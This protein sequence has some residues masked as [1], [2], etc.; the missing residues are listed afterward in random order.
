[1]SEVPFR[2]ALLQVVR[3]K[4]VWI[5]GLITIA[6][7]GSNT[8]LIGYLPLYLR[9][10]GWTPTYADSAMI[11]LSGVGCVGLILFSIR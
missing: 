8:G 5:I 7:W 3:I 4:E 10:I 1:M 11:L 2:Q 6:Q 9:G